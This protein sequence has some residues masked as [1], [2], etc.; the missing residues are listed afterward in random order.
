MRRTTR[1]EGPSA[2]QWLLAELDALK[3]CDRTKE[4]VRVILRSMVGQ[5]V[6]VTRRD[7]VQPAQQAVARRLID[8]GFSTTEARDELRARLGVSERTAQR[9]VANALH[10]RAQEHMARNQI[11]LDF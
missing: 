8:T 1:E 6:Y 3:G 10:A 11:Q 7:L 9:L 4:G 5:R 2:L